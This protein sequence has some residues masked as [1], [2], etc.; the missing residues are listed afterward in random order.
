VLLIFRELDESISAIQMGKIDY[1]R[2]V[3]LSHL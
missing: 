1:S 3:I 2:S